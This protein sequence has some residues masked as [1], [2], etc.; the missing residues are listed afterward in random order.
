VAFR[1]AVV[2]SR[3]SVSVESRDRQKRWSWPAR[4]ETNASRGRQASGTPPR[5][6]SKNKNKKK[7]AAD[8]QSRLSEEHGPRPGDRQRPELLVCPI[9]TGGT[10]VENRAAAD[11]HC[12][13]SLGRL[14][15]S[16][17]VIGV[18]WRAWLLMTRL[19]SRCGRPENSSILLGGDPRLSRA[20]ISGI[21][22]RHKLIVV[23]HGPC[24]FLGFAKRNPLA[25]KRRQ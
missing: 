25:E 15:R 18:P 19:V 17:S 22:R 1:F 13:A 11:G 2:L 3:G 4:D 5:L 7:L 9:A 8:A 23:M 6:V 21:S 16:C 14:L 12:P 20:K 10:G 24:G